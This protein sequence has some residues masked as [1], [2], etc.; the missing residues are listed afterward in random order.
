MVSENIILGRK[1]QETNTFEFVFR[2]GKCKNENE[3]QTH[4]DISKHCRVKWTGYKD[5]VKHLVE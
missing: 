2:E 4:M 5:F 1:M 3:P